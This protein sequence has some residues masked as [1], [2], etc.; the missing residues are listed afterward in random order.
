MNIK[1]CIISPWKQPNF[2]DIKNREF[3]LLSMFQK[4]KLC[5]LTFFWKNKLSLIFDMKLQLY[6][7]E[8]GCEWW[9]KKLL[10]K[11]FD[12]FWQFSTVINRWTNQPNNRQNI[13]QKW[14]WNDWVQPGNSMRHL[15]KL[16]TGVTDKQTNRWWDRW[17][18]RQ[19]DEWR[20]GK[21]DRW[22]EG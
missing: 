15:H 3:Y 11:A 19:T 7:Y 22:I 8:H 17:T 12:L 10:L 5:N 4:V 21:T 13:S 20:N 16:S 14:K 6:N 9:L 1:K 18:V 2:L